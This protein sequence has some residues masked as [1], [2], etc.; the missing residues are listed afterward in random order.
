MPFFFYLPWAAL[1]SLTAFLL[2][3]VDKARAKRRQWRIPEK[4]L[5]GVSILGGALGALIG[6]GLFRHKTKHLSFRIGIPACLILNI[7]TALLLL[8]L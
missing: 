3:G 5:F 2:F 6:M 7:A 8:F 4:V 1:M